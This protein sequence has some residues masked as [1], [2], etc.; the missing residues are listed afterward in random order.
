MVWN[1]GALF[2]LLVR[3]QQVTITDFSELVCSKHVLTSAFIIAVVRTDTNSD[4]FIL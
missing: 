4:Y 1:L 3:K 2:V